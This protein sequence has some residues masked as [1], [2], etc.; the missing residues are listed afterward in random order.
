MRL[1]A[2]LALGLSASV[3]VACS[4]D[5]ADQAR[6]YAAGL[7]TAL[8]ARDLAGVEVDGD[9]KAYAELI[10]PLKA[11]PVEV[12]VAGVETDGDAAEVELAWQWQVGEEPWS[13]AT[14]AQLTR[15]GDS[16]SVRWEPELVE[17]SLA[18]GEQLAL[19]RQS[20]RRG[21]ILGRGKTPIVTERDV[22]R[23]GLDKTKIKK[24]QVAPS[25]RQIARALDV[26]VAGF[27]KRA[28][29]AG[30]KAFVEALT[31]R[32]DDARELVPASFESIP[33]A[34]GIG[35]TKPL[36]PTRDFALPLLGTVGEATAEIVKESDGAVQPGDQVGISGLQARYDEQL[37][38][39]PGA[40]ITATG[41]GDPRVLHESE[42]VDGEPLTL[43]LDVVLQRRAEQILA[44]VGPASAIVAIDPAT[45]NLVAAASGP[46]STGQ[47]TATF[48]RYAPGSTM[49][50]VSSLALLRSGLGPNSMVECPAT[51]SVDGKRFKNYSDYPAASL[52]RIP[53]REAVAQSC[54]T[55]FVGQYAKLS[56]D[57][58]TDA[59]AAL[60]LGVD[61]D[62]GF[63][64]Y[65]GQV[66]AP[67]GKTE[68]AA[69]LI[70]QGKVLASPMA[71]ATV[72]ASVRAGKTVLPRLIV[73]RE[74]T[75]EEPAVPLTASEAK[76]LRALMRGVVT[77]GS[78]RF[79]ADLG[80][81]LGAKTGTA[82]YGEP[83]NSGA[84]ATHTWM[85]AQRPGLAV[86]VFVETGQSGS[87]TAGPLL[88]SF[89][90]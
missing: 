30:D 64:A 72:A 11:V 61:H 45:G 31:L 78:G 18:D 24:A 80:G 54:N 29:A 50:V 71:M 14:T 4:D 1:A 90:N 89:L 6:E 39:V 8:E 51:L 34:V 60:G 28:K 66:P 23:Y 74:V 55:A 59:A 63:P 16:W 49:K 17:P 70:G 21:E 62:L 41:D 42:P 48:G 75:Q 73:G 25:A 27:V 88:K 82:E 33:G 68:K 52:G 15:D 9:P 46:G 26:D 86:A 47:N 35:T 12:E 10:A 36:A 19:S 2:L 32:A 69:D 22:V 38:G 13:Y 58:L 76:Q 43:T 87:V 85:I 3:L 20:A 81:D 67:A 44:D 53:L 83:D 65:F 56:D 77:S 79:L 5:G 7:A 57:A 84:L 40:R 37:R